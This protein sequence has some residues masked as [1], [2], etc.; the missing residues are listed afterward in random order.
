MILVG[1]NIITIKKKPLCQ[2]LSQAKKQVLVLINSVPV[3]KANKQNV[4]LD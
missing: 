3:T 4:V 2:Q 1:S